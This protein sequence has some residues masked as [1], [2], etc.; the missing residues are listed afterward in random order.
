VRLTQYSF[1]VVQ[2]HSSSP[3][4]RPGAAWAWRIATPFLLLTTLVPAWSATTAV[5]AATPA[6]T[7]HQSGTGTPTPD[8]AYWLV[9]SDGGIFSFGGAGFYGSTG[10]MQL[11]KPVVGMAGTADG[12]GYWLVASDG[13]IFSFGD[14]AF[15]GSTGSLTLNK[16]I[17][18]MAPTSDGLGY[19]LVASDGGIFAFGDAPFFGSTGSIKLNKPIVGMAVTPD[20]GGY[21]LV[22]SDGGIFAFG[23]ARFHGSTGS[24]TLNSPIVGMAPSADGLGYML[25]AADG[26]VFAFGDAPF[27]GSLG[28]DPLKRPIVAMAA[29]PTGTG[30]WFTD[31]NGAVSAFGA[32]PYDGSAPQV[33]RKPVVGMAETSGDGA[34]GSDPFQS[35]SYGFDVSNFQ[36][37]EPLPSGHAIGVVQ[38][39]GASFAPVNPCLASEAQWAGGGLNLY[40]YLTYGTAQSATQPFCNGDLACNYGFAVAQNAYADAQAAGVN[41][42]VAW[43]LDVETADAGW[44][45]DLAENA[46]MVSGAIAG[47]RA[48][49]LNNV[50]I[51]ASPAVW[52]TIVGPYQPPVSYWMADWTGS[53][54]ASCADVSSY[55]QKF[56][57]P[58]GPVVLVQYTN[59]ADG[60]DGDYAC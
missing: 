11:N 8:P 18:G 43:W 51:Y 47:L 36:C 32:A 57:L 25:V 42:Q 33:I 20:G 37:G 22:A 59:D 27:Y 13:G 1:R 2:H 9:A 21:W 39:E 10:A 52:N 5:S 44:S 7:A 23:D 16:P 35:G 53:G 41:T 48:E 56:L 38:V 19:W 55:Q 6:V 40:V 34:F 31:D 49:G 14:A 3:T 58:S 15:H 17:V 26:G 60:F 50:G 12:L 45:P 46:Q 30:Y 24:L 54:P 4:R 29:V 28:G